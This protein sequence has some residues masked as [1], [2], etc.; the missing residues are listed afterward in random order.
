M[1]ST[2][3]QV[4]VSMLDLQTLLNAAYGWHQGDREAMQE[5]L[6]RQNDGS[7]PISKLRNQYNATVELY[8]APQDFFH[9]T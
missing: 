4:M 3:P 9:T 8:H 1:A 5:M 2:E 6:R 7:N